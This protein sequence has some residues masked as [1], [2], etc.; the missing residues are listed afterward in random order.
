LHTFNTSLVLALVAAIFSA[1]A[2]YFTHRRLRAVAIGLA[3][4]FSLGA[5]VSAVRD[6][7]DNLLLRSDAGTFQDREVVVT[8][9]HAE[10]YY[11]EFKTDEND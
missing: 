8:T 11:V 4:L 9:A 1:L 2:Y 7:A 10:G 5:V 3:V 6:A